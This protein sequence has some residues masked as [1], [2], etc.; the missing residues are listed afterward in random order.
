MNEQ[1]RQTIQGHAVI[2]RAGKVHRD[3]T[4]T[5]GPWNGAIDIAAVPATGVDQWA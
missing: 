1:P 3:E 5:P 2:L 4:R